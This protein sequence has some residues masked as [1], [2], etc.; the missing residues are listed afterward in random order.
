MVELV[1]LKVKIGLRPNGHADHPDWKRLP[2]AQMG[3]DPQEMINRHMV[4]SWNYDKTSGHQED[5]PE[6]PRGMQW[7]MILVTEQFAT[8]AETIFP[9]L[10]T[11]MT[12]AQ[13]RDF[14]E[15]KVTAHMPEQ[16]LD[17]DELQGLVAERELLVAR[18]RST[19]EVDRRIDRAL[20]PDDPALGV[21]RRR[22]KSWVGAKSH[23]GITV[24]P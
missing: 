10:M 23:L 17:R 3:G 16:G 14:W 19:V 18:G 13:A 2:L 4:I 9:E 5:T 22:D 12:E 1:P 8:E 7:G 11:R 15:T 21:R 20:D 24:K 6:S